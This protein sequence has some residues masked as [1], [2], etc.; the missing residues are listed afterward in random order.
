VVLGNRLGRAAHK[1]ETHASQREVYVLLSQGLGEGV[2]ERCRKY[3]EDEER[4]VCKCVL[5]ASEV[6]FLAIGAMSTAR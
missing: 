6:M 1:A 2:K 3:G 5:C 4:F